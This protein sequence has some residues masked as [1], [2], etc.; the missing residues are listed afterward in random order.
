MPREITPY[1]RKQLARVGFATLPAVIDDAGPQARRRFVEFFVANIRNPNTRIAY[2]RAVAR[3]FNW[4]EEHHIALNKVEPILVAA[5]IEQHPGSVPTVKQHLAAIR[6]L[7]DYLVI[8]Q[9]V[10]FNPAAAVRGPKH[11][12]KRGKTPVLKAEQARHLLDSISLKTIVGLRDR[13]I[14]GVMC[15]TFARVGAVV[16]MHVED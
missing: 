1:K 10:P 2:A 15:Y 16:A 4:C 12:V 6:M 11:V 3:F 14:L 7:F 8:G 9:V 5:Y 13:A